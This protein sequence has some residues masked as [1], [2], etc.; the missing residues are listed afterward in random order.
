MSMRERLLEALAECTREAK[1]LPQDDDRVWK[2]HPVV[3]RYRRLVR[4]WWALPGCQ[5]APVTST[6]REKYKGLFAPA[7]ESTLWCAGP[8]VNRGGHLARL[9]AALKVVKGLSP[10]DWEKYSQYP[11]SPCT[12]LPELTRAAVHAIYRVLPELRKRDIPTHF[13]LWME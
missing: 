11:E 4:R 10:A 3:V 12:L 6:D 9:H 8:H 5:A 7:R 13:N 2:Y 1:D